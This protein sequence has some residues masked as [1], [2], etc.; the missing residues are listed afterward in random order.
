MSPAQSVAGDED[1]I[2]VARL[3]DMVRGWFVGDFSP[4]ALRTRDSEV[5]VQRFAAGDREAAHVHRVATE[6]TLVLSGRATMC[7]R[8]LLAGDILTLPPGAVTSFH[9]LE[10]TVTVVV[11]TPSVIDDKYLEPE[12]WQVA[13]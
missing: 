1:G 12:T 6:V 4:A 3:D 5:A 13:T 8:E 10:D 7:G 11:K 9:A 2:V